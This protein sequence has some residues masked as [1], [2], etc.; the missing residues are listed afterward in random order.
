[1]RMPAS[2]PILQKSP[3]AFDPRPLQEMSSAH[4]G[5]LA[6]SRALR[7]LHIDGLVA[8]NLQLKERQRGYTESQ[9]VESIVLL[10]TLGGDCPEDIALLAGDQCL[11]RGLGYAPPKA[12]AVR[13]FLERF[14]DEELAALRPPREEQK[15]FIQPPSSPQQGLDR[16]L[17]GTVGRIAKLYRDQGVGQKIATV[18]QDATIIESHK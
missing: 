9:F 14:H 12:T 1:M 13:T 11:E 5:L 6:T 18:D 4:A 15:S 8:A 7:S 10:Q 17:A 16:I 3:F 2:I